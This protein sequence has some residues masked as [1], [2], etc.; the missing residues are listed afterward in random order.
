VSKLTFT[1]D[2]K[3]VLPK[4]SLPKVQPQVQLPGEDLVTFADIVNYEVVKGDDVLAA[5]KFTRY[6]NYKPNLYNTLAEYE[7]PA[8]Y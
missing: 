5:F 2:L 8:Y 4:Y 7:Q 1:Q 3:V 6:N